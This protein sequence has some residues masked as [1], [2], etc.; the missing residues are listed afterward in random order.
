MGSHAN[1][2]VALVCLLGHANTG[3]AL[4]A[5]RH[6]LLPTQLHWQKPKAPSYTAK[7]SFSVQMLHSWEVGAVWC[8]TPRSFAVRAVPSPGALCRP[9]WLPRRFAVRVTYA[10]SDTAFSPLGGTRAES[11]T[12]PCPV[13]PWDPSPGALRGFAVCCRAR[14][15]LGVPGSAPCPL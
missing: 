3:F 5:W 7:L 9:S 11:G 2:T 4:V 15:L 10:C 12:G 1:V 13:G 14:V 6:S 8:S